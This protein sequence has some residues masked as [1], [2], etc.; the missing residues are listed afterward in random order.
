MYVFVKYIIKAL[1]DMKDKVFYL[2]IIVR[3]Q[4]SGKIIVVY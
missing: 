2:A 4:F 1:S 3:Q